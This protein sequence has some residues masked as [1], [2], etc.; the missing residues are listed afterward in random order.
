M[1]GTSIKI[2]S[3]AIVSSSLAAALRRKQFCSLVV[4]VN[5]GFNVE[6]VSRRRDEIEECIEFEAPVADGGHSGGPVFAEGGGV[7]GLI[8]DRFQRDGKNMCRATSI[9]PVLERLDIPSLW[10]PR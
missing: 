6:A 9:L 8:I 4:E 5:Q 2:D 3:K 7:I 1:R 10:R